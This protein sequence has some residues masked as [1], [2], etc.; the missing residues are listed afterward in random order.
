MSSID[1]HIFQVAYALAAIPARYTLE[2]RQ[3]A[4][5]AALKVP[6]E[7]FSWNK[8]S[9][10][11]AII[12]FARG[13][14]AA[15]NGDAAGAREAIERLTAIQKSLA[16][17]KEDYWATQIEIQRLGAAAWLAHAEGKHDEA[18]KLMRAAADL[19]DT[20]EK[21]PVTPGAVLPA[22][23]LLGELLMELGEPRQALKEFEA[24]LAN[25]PNRFNGLYGAA[26]AAETSGDRTKAAS[27][28]AKLTEV[29]GRGDGARP[30]LQAAKKFL[31]RN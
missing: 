7:S 17:A 12:Y 14:G 30:E 28:Y 6:V 29:G 19:E 31:A 13:L 25:L 27:F 1:A 23:E 22:R 26:K 24:S 16:E 9:Y 2:R 8:F 4:E 15:R 3:W 18:L 11:E 10:A 20:T 21:H 5:A